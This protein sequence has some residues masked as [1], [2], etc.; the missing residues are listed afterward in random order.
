MDYEQIIRDCVEATRTILGQSWKKAKPYAEHEFK[1]FAENAEYLA[2]LNAEG[3]ISEE[4]L[5]LRISVQKTALSNVFLTIEGIGLV[6]AQKIVNAVLDIVGKAVFTA[7]KV[8][9]G[10]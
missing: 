7:L 9:I 6:T 5:H 3:T 1:Q 8:A 2:K 10:I 4:E